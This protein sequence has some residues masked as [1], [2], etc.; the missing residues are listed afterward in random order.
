MKRKKFFI[1]TLITIILG[2]SLGYYIAKKVDF[3]EI[4]WWPILLSHNTG[5]SML[6]TMSEDSYTIIIRNQEFKN[7]DIVLARTQERWDK[8]KK[9]YW[10]N[11]RV[12]GS[13]GDDLRI[14]ETGL[15][16]NNKMILDFIKDDYHPL[17]K[18]SGKKLDGYFLLGDNYKKSSDSLFLFMVYFNDFLFSKNDIYGK[19]T[20]YKIKDNKKR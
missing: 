11:K 4:R 15:Y 1:A 14:D 17:R 20:H 19:A 3:R 10:V 12:I 18:I 9:T 13:P 5:Q 8:D 6:P 7:G 16:I 2:S